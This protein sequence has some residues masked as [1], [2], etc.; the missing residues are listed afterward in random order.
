MLSMPA[1][2]VRD[3]LVCP[4]RA[5]AELAGLRMRLLDVAEL[6]DACSSEGAAD[7]ASW[8][9]VETRLARREARADL[10]LA[11]RLPRLPGDR[12][13]DHA[14]LSN[15]RSRS[16]GES[17]SLRRLWAW[18]M[19][20]PAPTCGQQR[21]VGTLQRRAPEPDRERGRARFLARQR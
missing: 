13:G 10:H 16:T 17:E 21:P 1:A 15:G 20:P 11:R 7:V 5:E 19:R 9:A 8:L 2:Q 3:R 12:D 14:R 18:P 4:A 6:T